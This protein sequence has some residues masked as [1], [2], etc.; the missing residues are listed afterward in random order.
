MKE[1]ELLKV[2]DVKLVIN[3][4]KGSQKFFETIVEALDI[5]NFNLRLNKEKEWRGFPENLSIRSLEFSAED[6]NYSM[7]ASMFEN[8]INLE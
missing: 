2:A 3:K 7:K 5:T 6:C 4:D 1:I 8:I